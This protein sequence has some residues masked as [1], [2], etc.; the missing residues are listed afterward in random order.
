MVCFG[1]LPDAPAV[2]QQPLD[3]W[4]RNLFTDEVGDGVAP[5]AF[6]SQVKPIIDD[7]CQADAHAPFRNIE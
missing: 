4:G 6:L 2:K 3:N 7:A 5:S 1:R